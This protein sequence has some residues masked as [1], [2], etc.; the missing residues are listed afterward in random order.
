MPDE[1]KQKIL[2]AVTENKDFFAKI[3]EEIKAKT[4][5]GMAQMQAVQLV[6]SQHK[7]ELTRLFKQ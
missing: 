6:M 3:A 4:D 7:E 2:S 5:G 1:T